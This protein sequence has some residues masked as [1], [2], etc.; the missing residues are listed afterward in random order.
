MSEKCTKIWLIGFS[1][2][3]LLKT[4][5]I[6]TPNT[7][8]RFYGKHK[9]INFPRFKHYKKCELKHFCLFCVWKNQKRKKS[10]SFNELDMSWILHWLAVLRSQW[11]YKNIKVEYHSTQVV[12]SHN[13]LL[14]L[15]FAF[16]FK[17]PKIFQL[18]FYTFRDWKS[19]GE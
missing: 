15:I 3:F 5:T 16:T 8:S 9:K 12:D 2:T 17:P 10:I 6:N 7:I 18:A 13:M 4:V 19:C 1:T 11:L 14:I